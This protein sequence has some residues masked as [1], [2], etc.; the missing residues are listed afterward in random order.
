VCARFANDSTKMLLTD[1]LSVVSAYRVQHPDAVWFHCNSLPDVTDFYWSQLWKFVPL[2]VVYHGRQTGKHELERGLKSA[3][4]SAVVAT[5]LE[6]GGI[7]LDWNILVVR[8]LNP[9][10]HYSVCLSKVGLLF[11]LL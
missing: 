8:S 9:L 4:D 2:T 10:R 7:F 11:V 6:H 3:R 1:F 5:L